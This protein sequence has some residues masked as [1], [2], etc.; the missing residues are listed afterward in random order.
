MTP[1]TAAKI[2]EFA[3][4][5]YPA[6]IRADYSGRGMYGK[7]T[8]AVVFDQGITLGQFASIVGEIAATIVD[9]SDIYEARVPFLREIE[10]L[11]TDSMGRDGIVIY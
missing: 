5:A 7:T 8:A 6:E 2:A 4:D 3:G 11:R 1:E 10:N 9:G